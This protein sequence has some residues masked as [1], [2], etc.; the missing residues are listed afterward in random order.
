MT[1]VRPTYVCF[2]MVDFEGQ[3]QPGFT[4]KCYVFQVWKIDQ[5]GVTVEI[6]WLDGTKENRTF[7]GHAYRPI[8]LGR[9]REQ[10]VAF[11]VTADGPFSELYTKEQFHQRVGAPAPQL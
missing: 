6:T 8:S 1:D 4:I 11:N 2:N 10:I 9:V 5:N 7:G 3:Y